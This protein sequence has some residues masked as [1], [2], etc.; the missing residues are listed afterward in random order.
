MRRPLTEAEAQAAAMIDQ[1]VP[2]L[3]NLQRQ[4]GGE[5]W[6][7]YRYNAMADEP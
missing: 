1:I 2:V 7:P 5:T 4:R 3:M 6:R